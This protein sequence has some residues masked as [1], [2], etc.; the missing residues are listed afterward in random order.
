MA[1]VANNK[2]FGLDDLKVFE[3][4][5]STPTYSTG[6]DIPCAQE[7]SF[8]IEVTTAKLEGDNSI[9]SIHSI[10]DDVKATINNGGVTLALYDVMFGATLVDSGTG[11]GEQTLLDISVSDSKPYFGV[12]AKAPGTDP[13]GDVLL[14][15]YKSKVVGGGSFAFKKGEFATSSWELICIP[16][17]YDSDTVMRVVNRV[18]A[19]AISTTWTSNPMHIA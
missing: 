4:T 15:M 9:C 10:T 13:A 19:A 5:A 8:D 2:P 11:S 6:T 16:S 17:D 12:I 3:R 14:I 1:T 7:I 18:T